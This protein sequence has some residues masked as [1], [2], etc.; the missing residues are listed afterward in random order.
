MIEVKRLT[1]DTRLRTTA[2]QLHSLATG[3]LE[4]V[5]AEFMPSPHRNFANKRS[6]RRALRRM[7]SRSDAFGYVISAVDAVAHIDIHPPR[8]TFSLEQRRSVKG[9]ATLIGNQT[10]IGPDGVALDGFVNAA[11][12]MQGTAVEKGDA[13]EQLMYRAPINSFVVV[14]PPVEGVGSDPN[15]SLVDTGSF[16]A[17]DLVV[18]GHRQSVADQIATDHPQTI[19]V[20]RPHTS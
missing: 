7:R 20:R 15:Q 17:T 3:E 2:A 11:M 9:M 1:R 10:L 4:P 14:Y 18:H 13:A 12:W 6:A 19:Y 5:L 16:E 8:L